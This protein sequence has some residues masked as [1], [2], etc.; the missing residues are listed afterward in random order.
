MVKQSGAGKKVSE[1]RDG[2]DRAERFTQEGTPG[3]TGTPRTKQKEE[4]GGLPQAYLTGPCF[5]LRSAKRISLRLG[6]KCG[7]RP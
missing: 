6:A 7:E 2:G 4:A 1:R 3:R 5:T